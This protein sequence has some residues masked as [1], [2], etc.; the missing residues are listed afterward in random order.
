MW[1][2]I[3]DGTVRE[4]T[5]E[6]PA[7][8]FHPSLVWVACPVSTVTGDAYGNGAFATPA[9]AA[10]TLAG[11]RAALAAERYT[12]QSA[13]FMFKAAGAPTTSLAASDAQ[14][15]GMITSSY[16]AA[17]G[18]HWA[19][20]T[21]WKMTDGS[22]VAFTSAEMTALA[23][24]VLGYVAACYAHEAE[25]AAALAADLSADITQGWPANT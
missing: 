16:V 8:R 4:L 11:H 12:R 20:G 22:F 3:E 19:D 2:L 1:A 25:L 14:S 23:L 18:G 9:A 17:A 21:P 7:G 5:A 13:G 6:D 15:I 24:K 10:P